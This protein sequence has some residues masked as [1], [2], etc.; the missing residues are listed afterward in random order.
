MD[1]GFLI[2]I[3]DKMIN[4]LKKLNIV[5]YFILLIIYLGK[6]INRQ[7][8]YYYYRSI[9]IDIFIIIKWLIITS[10]IIL[11]ISN[12]FCTFIVWYLILTNLLTY[13]YYHVWD[14]EK[15]DSLYFYFTRIKR[16]FINL[17]LA[18]CYSIF[19]FSYLYYLPYSTQFDWGNS[20]PNFLQSLIYSISNSLT[21]SYQGITPLTTFINSILIIQ[22]LIMFIFIS[23]LLSSSIPI[24]I[25]RKFS[26]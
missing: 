7:R 23:I 9:A 16:R 11:N 25:E 24:P 1:S 4:C 26:K 17:L 22:L 15:K 10:F 2:P 14:S 5:E 20:N 18:I 8:D 12:G 21:S 19:C 6:K 13:F 3:I